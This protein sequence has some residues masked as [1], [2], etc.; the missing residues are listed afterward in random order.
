MERDR[1]P[2]RDFRE[3]RKRP[4]P[5]DDSVRAAIDDAMEQMHRNA[6]A[7]AVLDGLDPFQRKQVHRHF[8][9][10][11]EYTVRPVHGEGGSVTL[12][13]YP[14]GGLRRMAESVVQEVLMNGEPRHLPQMGSFERFLVHEYMKERG[15]VRTESVGEGSERHVV[16]HPLFGRLPKKAKRRLT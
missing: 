2:R 11:Q 14:V 7:P 6:L 5:M 13:V 4:E 16:V 15:G 1:K 12:R 3:E 9:R 8:E 10:T